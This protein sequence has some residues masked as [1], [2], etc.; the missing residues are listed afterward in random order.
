VDEQAI[1]DKM[2]LPPKKK[3]FEGNVIDE[4]E[5]KPD[6]AAKEPGEDP[7]SDLDEPSKDEAEP[8]EEE[9]D[10]K[11]GEDPSPDHGIDIN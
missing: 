3:D 1:S 8:S 4:P 7:S 2:A 11:P 6:E 10:D 9:D 5:A